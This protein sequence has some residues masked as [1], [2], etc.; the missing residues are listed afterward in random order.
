MKA[1]YTCS[2]EVGHGYLHKMTSISQDK[3]IFSHFSDG[4]LKSMLLGEGSTWN[5][6]ALK[7]MWC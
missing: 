3:I 2:E 6:W 7:L 1:D 4:N 5:D